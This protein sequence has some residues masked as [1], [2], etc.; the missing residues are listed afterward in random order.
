MYRQLAET[1]RQLS[2]L[3][4]QMASMRLKQAHTAGEESP[5]PEPPER[6]RRKGH[7]W[8][9]PLLGGVAAGVGRWLHRTVSGHGGLATVAAATVVATISGVLYFAGSSPHGSGSG[10]A[11]PLAPFPRV[12]RMPNHLPTGQPTSGASP[13]APRRTST[14]APSS[15]ATPGPTAVPSS[16]VV[17][18]TFTPDPG[19]AT[20]RRRR[21]R[22]PA[23]Q[24]RGRTGAPSARGRRPSGTPSPTRPTPTPRRRPTPG[25][26]FTPGPTS[27]PASS[28]RCV[29]VV[30][31][32]VLGASVCLGS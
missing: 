7:L 8:L 19:R 22:P 13:T 26:T 27:A 2:A 28:G 18:Q 29:R 5:Q 24:R 17:A 6:A 31:D 1:R 11:G 21:R 14:A 20:A 12:S 15:S 25:P 4:V 16:A 23:G 10:H 32:P 3:R 30:V 9:V